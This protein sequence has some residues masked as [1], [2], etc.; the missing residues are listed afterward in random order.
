MLLAGEGR[1][2]FRGPGGASE[3]G[4]W[5]RLDAVESFSPGASGAEWR[6]IWLDEI[7]ANEHLCVD[8]DVMSFET[9]RMLQLEGRRVAAPGRWDHPILGNCEVPL[10]IWRQGFE[11]PGLRQQHFDRSSCVS[12][13]DQPCA[14]PSTRWSERSSDMG[15]QLPTF[16]GPVQPVCSQRE[17]DRACRAPPRQTQR[18]QRRPNQRKVELR[19]DSEK[20]RWETSRS[21]VRYQKAGLLSQGMDRWIAETRAYLLAAGSNLEGLRLHRKQVELFPPQG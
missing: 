17:C 7:S 9:R 2:P 12:E 18:R 10:E 19:R 4:R 11:D 3:V 14:T 8:N 15:F 20:G 6:Q 13:L 1:G 16:C 21:V 5:R